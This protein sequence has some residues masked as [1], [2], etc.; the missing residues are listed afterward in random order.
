MM[1]RRHGGRAVVVL[2][3]AALGAAAVTTPVGAQE[4]EPQAAVIVAQYP[5]RGDRGHLDLQ[6]VGA[7][8]TP[9]DPVQITFSGG[10]GRSREFSKRV[11]ADTSFLWNPRPLDPCRLGASDLPGTQFTVT[12]E[13]PSAPYS[14]DQFIT[15]D[16]DTTKPRFLGGSPFDSSSS[17][18][19]GSQVEV[20]D[21]I[22]FEVTATDKTPAPSWQ[23]GV[24]SLQVTG[25]Q[26]LLGS[27]DGGRLPKAC[28][29]K[30]KSLTVEGEH[31][32]KRSDPA[33][34]ELCAI[35]EDYV[36]NTNTKCA[37]W[38]K[39]EVWEGTLSQSLAFGEG[40]FCRTTGTSPVQF[41]VREG[42]DRVEIP[43]AMV[44]TA[45]DCI[46]PTAGSWT[47]GTLPARVTRN[48]L[49]VRGGPQW[50][51]TVDRSGDRISGTYTWAPD[52]SLILTTTWELQCVSC[53]EE[54]VG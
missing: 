38:Y 53:D 32:V 41:A 5:D 10:G 40:L 29:E 51:G 16:P 30:S 11:D 19:P 47:S 18:P 27:K 31:R 46:A 37:Q 45:S 17:P 33:V 48:A 7:D 13:V 54:A 21:E 14:L 2:V 1:R 39:G 20:G 35:A 49:T 28:G 23:T 4:G 15:L 12:V 52:E 26:G 3:V 36:P 25:P 34:I 8:F 43:F 50:A 44:E 42:T 9:G 22:N 24:H 6:A